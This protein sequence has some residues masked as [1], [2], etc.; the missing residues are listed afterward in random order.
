LHGGLLDRLHARHAPGNVDNL[1]DYD[2]IARAGAL[3]REAVWANSLDKLAEAVRVSYAMQL[4]EKMDPLPAIRRRARP[5][6]SFRW[7]GNTAAAATVATPVYLCQD[8]TDR[9]RLCSQLSFRAI[10]P[11]VTLSSI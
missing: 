5:A 7:R 6:G 10:E 9:D 1:R 2:A 4:G 11:Y 8:A 3:A